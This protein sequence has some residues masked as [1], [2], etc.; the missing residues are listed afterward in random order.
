MYVYSKWLLT[1][2]NQRTDESFAMFTNG[3]GGDVDDDEPE[4]AERRGGFLIRRMIEHNQNPASKWDES[5]TTQGRWIV[6]IGNVDARDGLG[7]RL[8]GVLTPSA[9]LTEH[10]TADFV[11][12][13]DAE[14]AEHSPV[15][16]SLR[17]FI[18]LR[19]SRRHTQVY[20]VR[21]V[22]G[23]TRILVQ[24]NDPD[25]LRDKV[26]YLRGQPVGV[27]VR[28]ERG[29]FTITDDGYVVFS[30]TMSADSVLGL[31]NSVVEVNAISVNAFTSV[32]AKR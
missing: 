7:S 24:S 17:A 16:F 20:S 8:V 23:I 9:S 26:S 10:L 11:D 13:L 1:E 6:G 19:E 28:A 27:T 12:L 5:T 18:E 21:L 25:A 14:R 30:D 31:M 22:E 3:V 2:G 32:K 4:L 29:N 15:V